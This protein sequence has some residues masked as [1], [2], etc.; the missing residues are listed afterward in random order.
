MDWHRRDLVRTA[1]A[2]LAAAGALLT[3]SGT[4]QA[5]P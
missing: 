5:R 3:G 2:W 1:V 4:A